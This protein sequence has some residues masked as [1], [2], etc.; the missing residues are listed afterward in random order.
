MH[1]YTPPKVPTSIPVIDLGRL[2]LGASARQRAAAEIHRACVETGFFYVSHHGIDSALI[3]KQFD[4]TKKFF[5]LPIK[6]KMSIWMKNSSAASGYEP[7]GGQVLDSQDATQKAA[8]PDLKESFY[9]GAELPDDHPYVTAGFR[10]F[11]KNQWPAGIAGFRE[12]MLAYGAAVARLGDTILELMALS[13]DLQSNW[14]APH[15][16]T[17]GA[18][19]R[20]IKYSPQPEAAAANQ[21]GA[22]AHTDW[23][24]ITILAQDSIG[25]L[26]VRNVAGE[27]IQAFP[28]P[29]TFVIN[30][31]DLMARWTNGIYKSNF[32]RVKNNTT[33][34]DRY[35]IPFF[36]SPDPRSVIE[37][38][39]TCVGDGAPPLFP[40][41]TTEEHTAEMFKRSYGYLPGSTAAG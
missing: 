30:L 11:G 3:E 21:L 19:L 32:H 41:C 6:E 16:A 26:E 14:F 23:G 17:A 9:C 36:Y 25:G 7:I 38:I 1:T 29:D 27:W 13:L 24:G 4:F 22:G 20:L 15:F 2:H 35:S 12:Q 34:R 31:G 18:K 10:G 40:S 8:P 5:D 39:P 28:I 33:N 37:A